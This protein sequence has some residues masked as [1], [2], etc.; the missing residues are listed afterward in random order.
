MIAK[1]NCKAAQMVA[2][3]LTAG[4]VSSFLIF[5]EERLIGT[6]RVWKFM[7]LTSSSSDDEI[8]LV[9]FALVVHLVGGFSVWFRPELGFFILSIAHAMMVAISFSRDGFSGDQISIAL[10]ALWFFWS[11][12]KHRNPDKI[13]DAT[14]QND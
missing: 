6:K 2:I 8:S 11:G 4:V 9:A 12:L 1:T 7:N 3:L 14:K 13:T 10:L 5:A